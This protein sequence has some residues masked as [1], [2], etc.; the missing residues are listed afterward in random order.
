MLGV[1]VRRMETAK[2]AL[3]GERRRRLGPSLS[4]SYREPLEIVRGRG[5]WLYDE[6]GRAYLDVV[7]NVAH[8]GHGHPRVVR[9]AARQMAILNT[10][11]RYLHP[12]ILR[13]ARRL[14]ELLPEPLSVCFF[15]CSGSE[16]NE[17]ALRLARAATGGRDVIVVEGAY[18]GNTAA[19]IDASPYKFDGPGGEGA[20]SERPRRSDAGRL[21]GLPSAGRPRPGREVRRARRGRGKGGARAGRPARGVSLRESALLRRADRAA[22]RLPRRGVPARTR[23]GHRVH[24]RRGP[25]RIRP[26]RVARLGLRRTG[27]RAGHRHDGQAHRQRASAGRRRDDAGDRRG[28]RQRH[29]VLQHVRRQPGRLRGRASRFST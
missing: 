21:P 22:A 25:G 23:G 11:T 3:R 18:H 28:V 10:N 4:L 14:T 2:E 17:L 8:V 27:R 9:A 24:R 26:R 29:G 6:S 16:A 13:Y 12:S 20:P 1:D 7:N 15:V 5:A 19:L